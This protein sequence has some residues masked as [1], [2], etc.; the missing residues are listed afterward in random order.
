MIITLPFK[1]PTVN[2]LYWHRG[3]IKILTSEA[4]KIRQQITDIVIEYQSDILEQK[5]L[6]VDI[7]I[8][9]NWLTKEQ[10]VARKDIANR[11]KFLI[12]SVFKALSIDDKFIFKTTMTK[13]QSIDKE[14]AVITINE[15]KEKKEEESELEVEMSK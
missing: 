6:E 14:Q 11:E 5:K 4:K 3:N 2:H 7:L 15:Y 13:V 9:E 8:Y 10:L 12:D 1:T